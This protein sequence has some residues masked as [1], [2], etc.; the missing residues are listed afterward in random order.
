MLVINV[1]VIIAYHGLLLTP[2]E[3]FTVNILLLSVFVMEFASQDFSDIAYNSAHSVV[4]IP[5][6]FDNLLCV[7]LGCVISDLQMM[8]PVQLLVDIRSYF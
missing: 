8:T 4:K 2:Y 3:F 1:I 6:M 5:E 7:F